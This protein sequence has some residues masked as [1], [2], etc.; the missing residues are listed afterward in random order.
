MGIPGTIEVATEMVFCAIR[1]CAERMVYDGTVV[2]AHKGL[3][4]GI[5]GAPRRVNMSD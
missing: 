3:A 4:R 2:T 1:L 5:E